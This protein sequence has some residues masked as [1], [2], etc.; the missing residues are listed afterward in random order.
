MSMVRFLLYSN[1]WDVEGLV[2]GTSTWMKTRVRPDVILSVLEAYAK[3][4]PNLLKHAPGF[5]SVESLRAVV[6]AGQ[7]GYGMAAV[8]EGKATTGSDLVLR[9]AEL[10]IG[11]CWIGW[12]NRRAAAR[13]LGAPRA[14]LLRSRTR[15]SPTAAS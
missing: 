1:Q 5:P 15:P 8:G 14:L 12:F 9:A 4:Q 10:G 3:V 11:T 6:K 2:A 7:A 13:A